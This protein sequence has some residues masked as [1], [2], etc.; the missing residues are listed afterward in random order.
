MTDFST[1]ISFYII[2][3]LTFVSVN[4]KCYWTVNNSSWPPLRVGQYEVYC[5]KTLYFHLNKGK[6][7][8]NIVRNDALDVNVLREYRWRHVLHWCNAISARDV[9]R[10]AA[11]YGFL[12][13]FIHWNYILLHFLGANWVYIQY[14]AH[15]INNTLNQTK[16]T[17]NSFWSEIWLAILLKI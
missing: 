1:E 5:P 10:T 4:V 16:L 7:L 8:Y 3:L 11:A 17:R 14:Y 9:R 6:K 2:Q 13:W 12:L 15:L